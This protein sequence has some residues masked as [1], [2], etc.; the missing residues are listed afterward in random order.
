MLKIFLLCETSA[1]L[2]LSGLKNARIK[3]NPANKQIFPTAE[4]G[5]CRGYRGGCTIAS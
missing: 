4:A 1:S 2:R 5:R 3:I